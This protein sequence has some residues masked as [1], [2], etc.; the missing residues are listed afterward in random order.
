MSKVIALDNPHSFLDLS[1]RANVGVG[2]E[3]HVFNLR[4]FFVCFLDVRVHGAI[5]SY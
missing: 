2:T 3:E 4:H 5:F 1:Y